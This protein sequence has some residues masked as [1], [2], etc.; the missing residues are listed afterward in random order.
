MTGTKY[1]IDDSIVEFNSFKP[2]SYM[3]AKIGQGAI[4]TS[5]GASQRLDFS[6]NVADGAARDYL[7]APTDPIGWR[8][9]FFWS[10]NNNQQMSLVADN[11]ATCTGDKVGDGEAIA[12]DDNGNTSAFENAMTV[13]EAS[14]DSL[15]VSGKLMSTQNDRP[16]P[17]A[18][19]YAEHWIQILD[20]P[21]LGQARQIAEYTI[22]PDNSRVTFK[23]RPAWDVAPVPGKS[24]VVVQ[25]QFWQVYTIN[26]RIDQRRPLCQKSNRTQP[27][28]GVI[29]MWAPSTDSVID[30]NTQLD[31]DGIKFQ[32][33]YSAADPK[34]KE[35]T[36]WAMAQLFLE[37]HGNAMHGKYDWDSNCSESG[38]S[39]W[40]GASPTPS[41]PPPVMG[42]GVS[43][44]HNTIDHADGLRGGA[45]STMLSWH[46]GPAPHEWPLVRGLLIQHNQ[47]ADIEGRMP[48]GGCPYSQPSRV[49]ISL[50]H[51][52]LVQ[53]TML[54]ANSCRQVSKRLYDGAARTLR[55]CPSNVQESCECEPQP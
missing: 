13:Q 32:Q 5:L 37:I 3:D 44:A 22:N 42:Y 36:S 43:I 14:I 45:I 11:E 25:R 49:G 4:A 48:T 34:C 10:L 28:G 21:G 40:Y 12:F 54:Y 27:K 46:A 7:Y 8:A 15:T 23:V 55:I 47:I 30:G 6:S 17:L 2:G 26:N 20:G 24:R 39:G 51:T 41:S 9:A 16:V 29:T 52:Q 31:A 18:E 35:C 38:I 50:E 1:R 53:G 19:Y 33:T